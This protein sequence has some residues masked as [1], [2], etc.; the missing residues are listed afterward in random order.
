M[1][2]EN[3]LIDY[4]DEVRRDL[5]TAITLKKYNDRACNKH[6]MNGKFYFK[7]ERHRPILGA[8]YCPGVGITAFMAIVEMYE[9]D[10]ATKDLKAVETISSTIEVDEID[11][12]RVAEDVLLEM[13]SLSI[14]QVS[15]KTYH[16]YSLF[17]D[18]SVNIRTADS[19]IRALSKA[20]SKL[21][22]SIEKEELEGVAEATKKEI[23]SRLKKAYKEY[24][25]EQFSSAWKNW[26][27]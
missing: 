24:I 3:H 18:V 6:E 22:F 27:Y 26:D 21:D 2:I 7:M 9:F 13:L 4:L 10:P 17:L 5:S 25:I 16:L 11:F 19:G 14:N 8:Q 1:S 20:A 15:P 23:I 12:S